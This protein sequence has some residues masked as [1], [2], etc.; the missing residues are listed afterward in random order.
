MTDFQLPVP[1]ADATAHSARLAALIR[2]QIGADGGAI[3]FSRS[4][5][6]TVRPVGP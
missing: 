3:P 5:R 2:D 4:S 6:V 1:D